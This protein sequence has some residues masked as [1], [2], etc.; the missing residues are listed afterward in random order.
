MASTSG[1]DLLLSLP[2]DVLSRISSLLRPPDLINLLLTCRS[3]NL[4][5]SSSDQIWHPQC[6]L[7]TSSSTLLQWRSRVSSYKSLCRFLS[8]LSPLVGCLWVH[9]NPEPGNT[10][11]VSWGSGSR[12]SLLARRIIPQEIAASGC[13]GPLL[14]SPVFEVLLSDDGSTTDF[15]LYGSDG[16][17]ECLYPGALGEVRRDCNV[18]SLDV[19][20]VVGGEAAGAGAEAE[21]GF[22]RLAFSDRQR[23][24]ELVADRVKARD[25]RGGRVVVGTDSIDP[26]EV[27]PVRGIET[28]QGGGSLWKARFGGYFKQGLKHILGGGGVGR[29]NS[30][31]G[32]PSSLKRLRLHEFLASGDAIGLRL[33]TMKMKV[34]TYRAWPNMHGNR[35]ALYKLA[36]HGPSVGREYAGL[37]GASFG[38]SCGGGEEKPWK[39]QFLLLLSYEEEEEVVEV[40][41]GR[42]CWL[43]AT[44]ILEG[45][46]YVLHPNGSAM[47]T[48]RVD[49]PSK[50]NF[51][52][53][54]GEAIRAFDGEGI[55]N[56]Y[57]FRY[58]GS[59]PGSLF[60]MPNGLLAFVWKESR[61]VL[62][63][64]RL[65]D[66][67]ELLEK[68]ERVPPL[69]PVFNFAYI[70][71][72][73]S[74]VF[75]G[76]S[77]SASSSSAQR[78]GPSSITPR[79]IYCLSKF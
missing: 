19:A 74:N 33:Q 29:A 40:A 59:K 79:F 62:T 52:L 5:L 54:S 50:E 77:R 72:S 47:F 24:L 3:L 67:D 30:G 43:I 71:K 36:L 44:K 39:A 34:S 46:H 17:E 26:G 68:G 14:W 18:L 38:W 49:E 42:R 61:T 70:T 69:S 58:P 8:S 13:G 22:G 63:L 15:V 11:H 56:G 45:T 23:L 35:F 12:P 16:G 32:V 37:W 31:L 76:F 27:R 48:V 10:V 20:V 64:Q 55:A 25:F 2:D 7:F 51:P 6:S 78:F 75:L 60:V 57:G 21:G 53:D 41:E 1:D 28:G 65:K 73:Y 66:I 9:Q 4:S